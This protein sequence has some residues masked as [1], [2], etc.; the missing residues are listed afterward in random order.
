MATLYRAHV[1]TGNAAYVQAVA[2]CSDD[3]AV[4]DCAFVEAYYCTEAVALCIDVAVSK[5]YFKVF[6]DAVFGYFGE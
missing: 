6:H 4:A 2:D 3:F 5:L 1:F